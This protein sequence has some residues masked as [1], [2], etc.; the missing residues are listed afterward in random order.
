MRLCASRSRRPAP[1]ARRAASR[2]AYDLAVAVRPV[3]WDRE[4][5]STMF[6]FDYT[7][8]R[9]APQPKRRYGYFVLP[10]R[11]GRLAGRPDSKAHRDGG[12][13]GEETLSRRASRPTPLIADLAARSVPALH[14]TARQRGRRSQRAGGT[15]RHLACSAGAGKYRR[16]LTQV[17]LAALQAQDPFSP[18]G[19]PQFEKSSKARSHGN[20][21]SSP[22]RSPPRPRDRKCA[23]PMA[24]HARSERCPGL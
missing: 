23:W 21:A 15:A 7:T 14:G 22:R 9:Y 12:L 1:H 3:V 17:A 16:G 2:D 4:R 20:Q 5:A 19:L 11:R 6:G 18:I 13:L 10:T 24:E 8:E